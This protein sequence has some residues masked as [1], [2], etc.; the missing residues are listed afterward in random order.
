MK[1]NS[2]PKL[3][4]FVKSYFQEINRSLQLLQISEIEQAIDMLFYAYRHDKKV[5]IL[6]NGGAA[7]TSSHMACDLSKGTVTRVYDNGEKRFRVFSLTDNASIMTAYANDLSF[8][9]VFVQQ[10]RNLVEKDD[11]VVAISGSGNSENVI[12]AIEYAK[13]RGAKT[14]GILGFTTG[15]KLA[16]KVNC[17]IIIKSNLYGPCE[18]IQLIL[19]HII[20]MWLTKNKNENFSRHLTRDA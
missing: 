17:P 18:D 4:K 14:I 8:N 10:L 7:S 13:K 3:K 9:D 12:R 6:G 16:K 19:N 15:G 5:F 20:V 1:T 2:N 11:V